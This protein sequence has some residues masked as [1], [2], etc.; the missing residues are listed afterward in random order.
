MVDASGVIN[1][2][3][4]KRRLWVTPELRAN[5]TLTVVTQ[6]GPHT[7]LAMLFQVGSSPTQC[8]NEDGS[9]RSPC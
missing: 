5:S 1:L 7:P 3:S 2:S 4:R 9:I 8:F 6:I